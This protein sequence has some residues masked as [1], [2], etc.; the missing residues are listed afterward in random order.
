MV[1]I[2]AV[3]RQSR[4]SFFAFLVISNPFV[5]VS[6]SYSVLG[7]SAASVERATL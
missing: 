3:L 5:V 6:W 4:L 2:A 7:S 1:D